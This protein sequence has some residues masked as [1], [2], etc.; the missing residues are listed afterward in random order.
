MTPSPSPKSLFVQ[1]LC[2]WAIVPAVSAERWHVHAS[3]DVFLT[4]PT[5]LPV[6]DL[7]ASPQPRSGPSGSGHSLS[8]L[9]LFPFS[10]L[11]PQRPFHPGRSS[12]PMAFS[13]TFHGLFHGCSIFFKSISPSKSALLS[14]STRSHTTSFLPLSPAATAGHLASLSPTHPPT[15]TQG[16]GTDPATPL[17]CDVCSYTPGATAAQEHDTLCINYGFQKLMVRLFNKH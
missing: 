11:S 8:L 1:G 7:S 16:H 5:C 12:P 14:P 10:V 3:M 4:L 9:L 2:Q 6:P 15:S 13:V 17:V